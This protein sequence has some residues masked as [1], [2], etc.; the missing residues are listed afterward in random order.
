MALYYTKT[1]YIG[2]VDYFT[3]NTT[4]RAILFI[5]GSFVMLAAGFVLS[6]AGKNAGNGPVITERVKNEETPAHKNV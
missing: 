5:M 1:Y 6:I 4:R 2:V 3:A